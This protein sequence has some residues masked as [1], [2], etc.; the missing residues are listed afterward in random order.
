M[1]HAVTASL[2]SAAS[3]LVLTVLVLGAPSGAER[4]FQQSG[5]LR[6]VPHRPWHRRSRTWTVTSTLTSSWSPPA[7]C[8]VLVNAGNGS[9]F[10]ARSEWVVES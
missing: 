2:G 4:R 9:F 8:K 1:R 5:L 7:R 10:D 6:D 3:A